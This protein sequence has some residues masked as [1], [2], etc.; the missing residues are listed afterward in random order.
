MADASSSRGRT[1]SCWRAATFTLGCITSNSKSR[2]SDW[3][4]PGDR[5]G[6]ETVDRLAKEPPEEA[7]GPL[8]QEVALDPLWIDAGEHL[9]HVD[10]TVDLVRRECGLVLLGDEMLDFVICVALMAFMAFMAFMALWHCGRS[11][12]CASAGPRL[13]HRRPA[14]RRIVARWPRLVKHDDPLVPVPS[15][16]A[17]GHMPTRGSATSQASR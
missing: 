8:P 12:L 7:I 6:S 9:D 14:V 16:G 15:P 13:S 5:P 3:A 2:L 17:C 10:T 1:P 11:L 4:S